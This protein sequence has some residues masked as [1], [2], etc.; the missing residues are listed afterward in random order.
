MSRGEQEARANPL[1]HA[2]EVSYIDYDRLLED[3]KAQQEALAAAQWALGDLAASLHGA[4]D[5]S[6]ELRRQFAAK[7]LTMQGFAREVGLPP[8][9]LDALRETAEAFSP[10][11]RQAAPSWEHYRALLQSTPGE[12]LTSRRKWLRE[13]GKHSWSPEQ[14]RRRLR[15]REK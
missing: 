11:D 13:V 15:D 8:A 14:L 3:F 10:R 5:A 1:G 7:G 12:S 6:P 2:L 4:L 9:R